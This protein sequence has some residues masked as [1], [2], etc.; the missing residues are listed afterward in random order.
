MPPLLYY[1][2]LFCCCKLISLLPRGLLLVLYYRQDSVWPRRILVD[3]WG[4]STT[5]Q[6]VRANWQVSW[7]WSCRDTWTQYPRGG[8]I[9]TQQP[10]PHKACIL[11]PRCHLVAAAA[12]DTPIYQKSGPQTGSEN[13][14]FPSFA[15]EGNELWYYSC[16]FDSE[17]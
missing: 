14:C 17:I 13:P 10:A 1:F 12:A 7:K 16:L 4:P 2:N 3:A 6:G 5:V 8:H 15:L 9:C 11:G